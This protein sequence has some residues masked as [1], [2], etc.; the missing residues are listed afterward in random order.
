[1]QL[2]SPSWPQHLQRLAIPPKAALLKAQRFAMAEGHDT[3]QRDLEKEL[4][5]SVCLDTLTPGPAPADAHRSAKK[6]CSSL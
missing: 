5:C 1:M 4:T 3:G 2:L 6:C